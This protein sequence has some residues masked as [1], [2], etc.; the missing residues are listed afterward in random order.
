MPRPS[1]LAAVLRTLKISFLICAVGVGRFV[2]CIKSA[3]DALGRVLQP[4]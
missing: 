3:A 1:L 2:W 4:D